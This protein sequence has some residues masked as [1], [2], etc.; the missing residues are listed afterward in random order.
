MIPIKTTQKPKPVRKP[1]NADHA[2]LREFAAVERLHKQIGMAR[3]WVCNLPE[4][5]RVAVDEALL[6]GYPTRA[7]MARWLRL[8]KGYN[9]VP[10]T[11]I[12][13]RLSTHVQRQHPIRTEKADDR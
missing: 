10:I 7:A 4:R 8:E 9:D 1:K 3:C 13:S 5:V 2:K 12:Q 6:E 11:T